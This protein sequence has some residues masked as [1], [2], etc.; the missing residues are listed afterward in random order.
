MEPIFSSALLPP[1]T[2]ANAWRGFIEQAF[3]GLQVL[4][5]GAPVEASG[6]AA[7]LSAGRL[8]TLET[9]R[10]VVRLTPPTDSPESFYLV[11]VERGAAQL[12]HLGREQTLG[13]GLFALAD[14]AEPLEL[15]VSDGSRHLLVQLPR[16]LVLARMPQARDAAGKCSKLDSAADHHLVGTLKSLANA[17]RQMT[18]AERA[19]AET[20]F[21]G[22][23]AIASVMREREERAGAHWRSR[24]LAAIAVHAPDARFDA[25]ALAESIGVS[26]RYLDRLFASSGT[27]TT[28]LIWER[29]LE[30]AASD[31]RSPSSSQRTI[32][33][34]ALGAG[35]SDSA[36]FSRA[37]R[38]R[39]GCTPRAWRSG[40]LS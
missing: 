11:L 30:D 16:Q 13:A 20:S 2:R 19:V 37:F 40:R 26:R 36:H 34:I 29:R 4:D 3:A 25:G 22:L 39:F 23:L 35:F 9:S 7:P 38:R 18:C 24:A 33:D 8:F 6:C 21:L 12:H 28:R 1:R 31:L 10:K 32:L 27:S 5:L 15:S 17:A 14:G